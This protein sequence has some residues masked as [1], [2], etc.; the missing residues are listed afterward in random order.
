MF[1]LPLAS[2]V[3]A[4]CGVSAEQCYLQVGKTKVGKRKA[5]RKRAYPLPR[6]R[7]YVLPIERP[8]AYEFRQS[9]SYGCNVMGCY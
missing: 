3:S 4:A 7:P 9:P 5:Y 8:P 2:P 6:V 1:A